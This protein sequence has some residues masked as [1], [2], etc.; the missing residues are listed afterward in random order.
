VN[1][2]RAVALAAVLLILVAGI[3]LL[4]ALRSQVPPAAVSPTATAS[5]TASATARPEQTKPPSIDTTQ[6]QLPLPT[7]VRWAV[8]K[9]SPDDPQHRSLLE[10]FFDGNAFGFRV[11]DAGGS[12]V[13]RFPI[14]G[15]G[16][17][18]PETCMIRARKPQEN[19]T[20]IAVDQATLD[21]FVQR[22]GSYR[23]IADGIP[24]GQV[25]L[26]LADSG[27]RISS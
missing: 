23:V 4:Y 24:A 3:A 13:L 2:R 21:L 14:A 10:L 11:V 7:S 12:M 5:P 20:W 6:P 8:D 22:S 18:G 1:S 25:T 17:F 15:S 16:I 19:A 26:P 27:C 9:G